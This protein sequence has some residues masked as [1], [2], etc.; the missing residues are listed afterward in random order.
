[1]R[2]PALIL[3]ALLWAGPAFALQ[4][5]LDSTY[6]LQT[7]TETELTELEITT[8]VTGA[9][10]KD[11]FVL[12]NA[13][14]QN[15]GARTATITLKVTRDDV[16][17]G[18]EPITVE[19]STT[20]TIQLPIQ[21]LNLALGS[22]TYE[23]FVT[24]DTNAQL[25][26]TTA[27][28]LLVQGFD[29]VTDSTVESFV[30]LDDVPS[31]YTSAGSKLV[32]VNA[33][34]TA[35]EFVTSAPTATALAANP[36]DCSANQFANAIAAS[37]NLTC[38]AIADADVPNT[39][40]IDLAATATALAANGANCS[41]GQYPLGVDASGASESCTADDDVPESGDFTNLALS[42]DVSSSALV[43]TIGADK[44]LESHL[45]AVDAAGDEECL[46]YE[47]TT[48][49]F[50]WQAC[51]SGG[52]Y[53]TIDDEDT[54]LTQRTTLNFEGAGVTCADDT[55]QTTC[56][57]SGSS[58]GKPWEKFTAQQA[59]LPAASYATQDTRNTHPVLDFDAAADECAYF[60][61]LLASTY[62]GGG[63]NVTLAWLATSATTGATGWL[64]AIEAHPDDALDLDSDSFGAD[65]SAS[66]TTA[67]ATG[68]VQYT[69][70]TFTD[71]AD[72]DSL[73]AGESYRLRVCRDGDGSVV[74]DDM[75]GDAELYRVVVRES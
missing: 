12:F 49:D 31:A 54:P 13:R 65:N 33:G 39:I 63:L 9:T 34:A 8:T 15:T 57:I 30:D 7:T 20:A 51:G 22:H 46:T 70:I 42:G 73:A 27:T 69:D 44:V 19:A 68:E 56:T 43:T 62:A 41:A 17:I 52:G 37:G 47:T 21:D 23:A 24:A 18:S 61:G 4:E 3:A 14:V 10:D 1:V 6:A 11:R 53:A 26:F 71:G 59:F 28:Y 64:V 67:S 75:T 66:A 48:G 60:G 50:E 35:L 16:S 2:F 32:A 45:K 74:T 38:A 40:T 55:D 5:N 58:A 29:I 36:S 72:M 25:N